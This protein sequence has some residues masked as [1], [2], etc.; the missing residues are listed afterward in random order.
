[1]CTTFAIKYF[2]LGSFTIHN[3]VVVLLSRFIRSR[4]GDMF[5]SSVAVTMSELMKL[6]ICIAILLAQNA[7]NVKSF[8]LELCENLKDYRDT[9]IVGIPGVVYAIQ[10]V[11]W[12]TAASHLHASVFQLTY[13]LKLVTT[14]ALFGCVMRRVLTAYHWATLC[15]LVFGVFLAQVDEISDIRNHLYN[16]NSGSADPLF[17]LAC[18]LLATF[19]SAFSCVFIEYLLKNTTKSLIYRNIQLSSFGILSSLLFVF[20]K[21]SDIVLHKSFF[22]G[23]DAYVWLAVVIQSLGGLLTAA[24]LK[25]AD[26]I[27]KGFASS[28]ALL[29]TLV[30]SSIFLH[31]MP[32]VY[33]ISGNVVVVIAT[34]LYAL[35][36]PPKPVGESTNPTI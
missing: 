2:I 23:F 17:G 21:D 26:N 16:S 18:I 27:L 14:A 31:H 7:M 20:V 10:S 32:T 28:I 19:L 12:Y 15:L 5:V 1:M 22:F 33:L 9:L 24:V 30:S 3:I 35:L 25:Y 6:L 4:S 29:L 8:A 11:L 36:T 34:I 13:Q